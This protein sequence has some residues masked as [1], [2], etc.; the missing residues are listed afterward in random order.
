VTE[1]VTLTDGRALAYEEYGDPA[2]TPVLSFHGGLSSRLDA[3]TADT[4]AQELGVRLISPDRPGMGQSDF[5]PNRTLLDWPHDVT[6]LANTLGLGSFAV[7][8]WSAGGPYAAVCAAKLAD[9]INAVALLSSSV[10]L[11]RFGTT[12]GLTIDDRI[13]LFLTERAPRLAS[14]LMRLTIADASDKRLHRE[15]NRSFPKVDRAILEEGDTAMQVVA[16]VR[17]SMRNGTEGCILDY[18][19]FGAPWGFELEEIEAPVSIWEGTDDHTGPPEYR[20]YLEQHIAHATVTLV[21][22]EGHLSLLPHHA[23]EILHDLITKRAI[24]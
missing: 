10:P 13:M 16:F 20:A 3:A 8:G 2:G 7:M 14:A 24:T 18:R 15:L 17:E 1:A 19:I 22:Q 4:A 23:N 5:Q 21:P 11:D 12:K 6:E 9:R